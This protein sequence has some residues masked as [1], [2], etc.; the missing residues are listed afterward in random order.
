MSKPFE[1][2][3]KDRPYSKLEAAAAKLLETAKTLLSMKATCR[4][5]NGTAP[6]YA[7]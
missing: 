7:A 4:S 3:V 1:K 6:S 2:L 5:S